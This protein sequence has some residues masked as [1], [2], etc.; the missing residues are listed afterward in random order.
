MLPTHPQAVEVEL[1]RE[2]EADG[3][4]PPP[5]EKEPNPSPDCPGGAQLW[6][7]NGIA[8]AVQRRE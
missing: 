5:P 3:V 4:Y 2:T 6:V 1:V 7:V 8:N